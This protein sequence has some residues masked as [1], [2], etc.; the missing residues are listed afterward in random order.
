[1]PS[2]GEVAR[3]GP[4]LGT[5]EVTHTDDEWKKI[6]GDDAFTIMRRQGT[7]PPGSSPLLDEHRVGVFACAG[8]DLPLY[9]SKHQIRQRHRLA[10]LSGRALPNA[11]TS[12][13]SDTSAGMPT[14]TNATAAAAAGTSGTSS[15]MF[16]TSRS[17]IA[18]AWT[19][20]A[21]KFEPKAPPGRRAACSR[22]R[23]SNRPGGL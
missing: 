7:E 22:S 19:G 23:Q 6:L 20:L 2:R 21:L 16:P 17:T 1:M 3:P 13:M 9:D 12:T 18:I 8:C 11:V 10:E 5:F 4:A 14:A 15:T